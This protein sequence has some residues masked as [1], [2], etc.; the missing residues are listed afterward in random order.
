MR[1]LIL[2]GPLPP[3]AGS[4]HAGQT[5]TACAIVNQSPPSLWHRGGDLTQREA[6]SRW[7]THLPSRQRQRRQG[8]G[9]GSRWPEQVPAP[10]LLELALAV[11]AWGAGRAG[12]LVCLCTPVPVSPCAPVPLRPSVHVLMCLCDP[13]PMCVCARVP[14]VP[15]HPRAPAPLLSCARVLAGGWGI[16][17]ATPAS[18]CINLG[19]VRV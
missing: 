4:W 8:R 17:R 1:A 13:V 15:V 7:V 9:G 16:G 12:V 5:G 3:E 2:F 18:P 11:S 19:S 10:G 14:H 6:G